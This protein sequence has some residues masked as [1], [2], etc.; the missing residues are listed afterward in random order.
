M[1]ESKRVLYLA[2][3]MGC[4]GAFAEY[5]KKWRNDVKKYFEKYSDDFVCISPTDYYEIG[6]N[7][8][9]TDRETMCFDL[10]KV[11]ESDVVLVNLKDLDKSLGTS[12]EI[13]YA[14]MRGTPVIGFLEEGTEKD[15]HPWKRD[16]QIER[17]EIGKDSMLK[18]M[19]YIRNYYS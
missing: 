2:G 9:K 16:E 10:R 7:Y 8:H 1:R 17:I 19:E 15:I 13:L 12:D 6:A 14:W 4:Y 18:A 5:P 11:R 3:A